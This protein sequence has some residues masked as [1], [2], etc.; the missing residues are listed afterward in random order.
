MA[1]LRSLQFLLDETHKESD[2]WTRD[3][4]CSIHG[5]GRCKTEC[6][7]KNRAPVP[8]G[9]L[10]LSAHRNQN[11]MLWARYTLAR[12]AILQDCASGGCESAK[13]ETSKAPFNEIDS[14]PLLEEVNEWRLLHG[15]SHS[16]CRGICDKNF[17][18]ALAGTGSTWKKKGEA[19]GVSLY[20]NGIYF[21]ERITK[22]DEYAEPVVAASPGELSGICTLLVCRVVGGRTN[23]CMKN[24]I[25]AKALRDQV[26]A[27][28]HHSVLGD[29]V[30]V[31]GK[32]Y[33]EVVLYD[34]D[35]I[36]P[37]FLITYVRTFPGS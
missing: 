32:P 6:C 25:D 30:K 31:L 8:T 24:E 37:E 34:K 33:R 10:L 12:A 20:G 21:A 36:Y 4:G 9:Y 11:S 7:Y 16:A 27:G 28:P 26:F 17:N 19:K 22:A 23:V 1:T 13:V 35:Q 29:R 5:V 2:N 14:S 18:L 15:S 3:R